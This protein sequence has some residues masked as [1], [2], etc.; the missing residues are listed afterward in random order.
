MNNYELPPGMYWK[1]AGSCFCRGADLAHY[2]NDE[3]WIVVDDS[4]AEIEE[5]YLPSFV[6]QKKLSVWRRLLRALGRR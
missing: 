4:G 1:Y 3:E 2:A 6:R 5:Q